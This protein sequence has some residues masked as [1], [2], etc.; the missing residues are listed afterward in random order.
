MTRLHWT[1]IVPVC[2]TVGMFAQQP[3]TAPAN[4]SRTPGT[5]RS[6]N[7]MA[8]DYTIPLCAA[9]FHDSLKTDHIA[10]P[11]DI[12]VTRPKI[13]HTVP[14]LITQQAID[15]SGRTHIGNYNVIVNVVVNTKGNPT[16]LCLQKS[17][18]YGLD[19]AAA[20]AVEQYRFDPAAKGGHP[21][22]MR[23]PV[24]V[25]FLSQTPPESTRPL[26]GVAGK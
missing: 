8:G 23:I 9:R 25:R 19:A 22:K 10:G 20:N 4:E 15:A 24:E 26:P 1:V 13:V 3:G 16:E 6:I 14:A 11:H 17:S 18:G 5:V 7:S 2:L 12:G 21:V